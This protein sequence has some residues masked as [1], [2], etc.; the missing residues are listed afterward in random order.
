[1]S[2]RSNADVWTGVARVFSRHT[3]LSPTANFFAVR[4]R[5][6]FRTRRS[7]LGTCTREGHMS[8]S[9]VP[10]FGFGHV[11][12]SRRLINDS[13][14]RGA[15]R[16]ND[17]APFEFLCECR[18]Q[19]CRRV[20]QLTAAQFRAR[21]PGAIVVPRLRAHDLLA[22]L[23]GRRRRGVAAHRPHAG[24]SPGSIPEHWPRRGSIHPATH[25]PI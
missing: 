15:Q 16:I 19:A 1:M 3:A 10:A 12:A 4:E 2:A 20:E 21:R 22:S 7:A 13:I 23:E 8:T 6:V 17:E 24:Q 14:A 25:R 18:D 9:E 11:V 5:I